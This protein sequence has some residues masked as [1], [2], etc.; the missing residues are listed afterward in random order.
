VEALKNTSMKL[1]IAIIFFMCGFF[2]LTAQVES[3]KFPSRFSKKDLRKW[4]EDTSSCL[5]LRGQIARKYFVIREES[6]NYLLKGVSV[7]DVMQR[8][9]KP[10]SIDYNSKDGSILYMKYVLDS[11]SCGQGHMLMEFDI[12][13][14]DGI[15]NWHGYTIE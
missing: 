7:S 11:R 15:V 13:F 2:E 12:Q 5:H 14:K 8:L 9:G 4:R 1:I 10:N 6:E 3:V